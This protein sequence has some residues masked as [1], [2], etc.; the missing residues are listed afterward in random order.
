[1]Y[2]CNIGFFSRTNN[3][4]YTSGEFITETD[5]MKLSEGE[6]RHFIKSRVIGVIGS[7]SYNAT[8]L[9]E[10]KENDIS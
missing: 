9:S 8:P 10:T 4:H 3:K 7:S 6:R 5:L 1:M 2:R